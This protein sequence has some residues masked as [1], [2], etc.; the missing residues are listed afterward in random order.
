M[1]TGSIMKVY[2]ENI[3][4]LSYNKQVILLKDSVLLD[5]ILLKNDLRY[6]LVLS[7]YRLLYKDLDS[8]AKKSFLQGNM[9]AQL[10]Y[11]D[12]VCSP[13]IAVEGA[14]FSSMVSLITATIISHKVP[15]GVHLFTK[16][17]NQFNDKNYQL[18]YQNAALKIKRSK[19]W[20][21]FFIGLGANVVTA[22]TVLILLR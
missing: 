9:D 21:G 8:I 1:H 14:L 6:P 18:G 12:Q 13:L 11:T 7:K 3:L 16:D 20:E 22:T 2:S 10:Y 4:Q 17:F 5:S 19:V 15:E